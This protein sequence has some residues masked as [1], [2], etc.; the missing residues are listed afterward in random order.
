NDRPSETAAVHAG[1]FKVPANPASS[2]ALYQASSYE[3]EDL[4]DVEAIYGG[5]R[6]GRIYGRYGGP[7]GA[8]FEAA[9]AELEG[10]EAAA[11]AAAGMSAIGAAVATRAGSGDTV[12]A[13]RDIYGGTYDLFEKDFKE[14][15]ISV[16]Y[17]DQT[18]L[19]AVRSALE[20]HAPQV[21]YLEAL[22][23]PLMQVADLP[24]LA[25]LAHDAGALV[26]VDATFATPVLAQPLKHGVDLVVHSVGKYI[27]GH[28]DVNAGVLAGKSELVERARGILIRTGAVIPHFEA[29]L[30]LRG[31]RTLGL[32]MARHSASATAVAA[33]LAGAPGVAR[34]H[35]PSRP[36]H[37]QHALAQRLYPEGTGGIVAF[38]LEGGR[39]EVERFLRGLAMIALV[40]SFGEVASTISY[41]ALASHRM[42]PAEIRRELGV[43]D[44]TLRLSVGIERVR[45]ITAD[46][47]RALAGLGERIRA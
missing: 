19:G 43:S 9:V 34:V 31:L 25:A 16:S 21:L 45:D 29:W 39:A 27:G 26:V 17:V 44:A 32:R 12:L 4:D 33:Y 24:A 1:A 47:A 10:A 41:P 8:Q 13:T 37:P 15:G 2:P 20:R 23:N 30:G 6:A 36:E 5:T 42:F 38:E 14:R 18:D 22:T 7:N 40:H 46:L 11:G 35:H 3:F 28:G